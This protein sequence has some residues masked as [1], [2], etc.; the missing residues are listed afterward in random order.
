MHNLL[1]AQLRELGLN[2][3]QP[4][5]A[6]QWLLVLE[7][8]SQV[9]ENQQ[10]AT[11][12]DLSHL[13]T[14]VQ[15]LGEGLSIL[16]ASGRVRYI[17]SQ[18]ER[19]LGYTADELV[20][21][22]LR[23]ILD[24]YDAH[25]TA[26]TPDFLTELVGPGLEF[27]NEYGRIRRKNG[28]VF[29]ASY[30][31]TPVVEDE[32]LTGAV[33]VFRDMTEQRRIE[34]ELERQVRETVLL[35]RV[36][37]ATTSTGDPIAILK[38][39][40][41]QLAYAL[42]LPQAACAMLDT[43]H[44]QLKVVA[45]YLEPGRVS[46]LGAVIP[47]EN[48]PSTQYILE[49]HQPLMVSDAPNDERLATRDLARSRGTVSM[50]LVPLISRN[51]V[52]GTLGLNATAQREFTEEEV[53]MAQSVAAAASQALDN[54]DLYAKLENELEER[55]KVEHT[56]RRQN[57]YLE[58]LH[59]T[60]LGL[61]NRLDPTTV[62]EAIVAR[63]GQ[64]VGTGDGYLYVASG[65]QQNGRRDIRMQAGIG[66]FKEHLGTRLQ[67]GEGLSGEVWRTGQ[68]LYVTDYTAWF[69]RPSRF[70]AV[71]AAVSF[72]LRSGPVVTGVIGLAFLDPERQLTPDE[73]ETL[74]RFAQ[75]ASLALDNALLYSAVQEELVER[76]KTQYELQQAILAAQSANQTKS[77]FLATM[78]HELRTPLNAVIGYSELLK[79]DAEVYGYKEIIPDLQKIH[80][81]GQLLLEII[82]D[83]LDI[84]R[85]EAGETQLHYEMIE[86]FDLV[87]NTK[88]FLQPM[89][90]S[91]GNEFVMESPTTELGLMYTDRAKVRQM[92][93][94]LLNNA[95]KFTRHGR[96][97]LRTHRLH[98]Q[99]GDWVIFEVEDTGIGIPQ[100]KFE[101]IFEPFTQLDDST[102]RTYGG[103][104]L[105]LSISRNYARALGGDIV[106]E[107]EIGQGSRFTVRLPAAQLQPILD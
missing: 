73:L 74:E 16:E 6:E 52:I 48:N 60:T 68:M 66:I 92:L 42:N 61:L 1:K 88:N 41:T 38:I 40:C 80:S 104:G 14:A 5:T 56:L 64:L 65:S 93:F 71:K 54:A 18:G 8:L 28:S 101:R 77:R 99:G 37:A 76:E 107:S 26:G 82:S 2:P 103:A 30:V 27:R 55:T 86:V 63:A 105:G 33:L 72:P 17:N 59:G 96:V 79:E 47:I 35:N 91:S 7:Q 20:G 69:G 87:Q 13:Q 34:A 100:E 3:H 44:E 31:I 19:L 90:D 36:I 9:Y 75:L 50:L 4:P 81:A 24:L 45:E 51:K 89:F 32:K 102:T 97:T 98:E 43:N 15:S 39:V 10:S 49:T 70:G 62:L 67:A 23:H 84:S 25:H 57:E 85:I 29:P 21:Q 53:A 106:V 11:V 58:I 22:S 83:I 95:N 78:S 94:N 12:A 46:A